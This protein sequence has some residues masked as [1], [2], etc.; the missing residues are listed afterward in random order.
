ML[1][2]DVVD[3]GDPETRAGSRHPR[4]DVRVFDETER[5]LIAA[6]PERDRERWLLWAAKESAYKAARKEDP[7]T[8]FAPS[9]FVVRRD[10][11]G[12]L[13]VTAGARAFR[14]DV[15]ANVDHVHAV[16]RRTGDP[17]RILCTA[18]ASLAPAERDGAESLA[19]RRLAITALAARLDVPAADLAVRREGRIPTLWLRGCRTAADLSLSHHGRFVAFACTIPTEGTL[20]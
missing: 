5:V 13:G 2:N 20:A 19:V 18:V 7:R 11:D 8:I 4:F 14:I 16:A 1:G 6:S 12:R 10:A 17:P 3:L 15:R 9:R